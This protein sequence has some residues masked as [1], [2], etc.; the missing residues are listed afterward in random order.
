MTVTN[1][2][3]WAKLLE[4]CTCA[5]Q[6]TIEPHSEGYALYYG[7]CVH[8]HGYNLVNM[9]EPA[10]NFEPNHIEKLINLGNAEYQKNPTGGHVAE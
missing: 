10:W 7:R 2:E 8:R 5:A 3:A 6:Y 4:P 9:T 1:E